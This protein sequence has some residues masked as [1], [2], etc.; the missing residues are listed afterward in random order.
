[1]FVAKKNQ[2]ITHYHLTIERRKRRNA[3]YK[4]YLIDSDESQIE[5]HI[6]LSRHSVD[7]VK[8][9]SEIRDEQSV[10]DSKSSERELCSGPSG[11]LPMPYSNRQ[12]WRWWWIVWEV[13]SRWGLPDRHCDHS[14]R[15]GHRCLPT[16]HTQRDEHSITML[17]THRWRKLTNSIQVSFE[18]GSHQLSH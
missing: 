7:W 12:R 14:I 9:S 11:A 15:R 16:P 18:H 17:Q 5:S 4:R 13:R 3:I 8:S 10:T 2:I 1:M 6:D